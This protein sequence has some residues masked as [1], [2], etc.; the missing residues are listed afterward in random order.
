MSPGKRQQVWITGGSSGIGLAL[1]AHYVKRGSNLVLLAR[2]A[3]KLQTAVEVCSA[4]LD[5]ESQRVVGEPVDV[6]DYERLPHRV[7]ALIAAR[8]TPDLLIHCAGSAVNGTFLE[9]SGPGF[10]NLMDVNLSG[11][12]E[13]SRLV[14]PDMLQR[15]SGQIVFV[16][17]MAGLTG[18]YGYTAYCASKFA[19]T[20]FAL[21]L[22]QELA[23]SGV[24]VHL[25]CP[26]EVATP[27][28]AEEAESVLP[29]T[30][31][32]KDLVGTLSPEA[33]AVKIARG[34]SR[35]KRVIIPGL[36]AGI[37]AW[38]AQHFPGLFESA[39]NVLLHRRFR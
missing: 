2:D 8:G 6:T 39:G 33:A 30:R 25:V 35:R 20:G 21:A 10:D 24:S 22:R 23:G 4:G 7:Q 27:M 28:I 13:F 18:I 26:P 31:F 34:I 5:G 16:S 32:L 36:R 12:R 17:S 1:G 38:T 29:Q 11:S 19:V 14:L 9:T 3:K 15:G 37:V